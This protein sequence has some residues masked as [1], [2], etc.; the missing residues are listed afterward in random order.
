MQNI[1]RVGERRE[2]QLC[3]C[4]LTDTEFLTLLSD[5]V[6]LT[7]GRKVRGSVQTLGIT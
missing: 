6:S 4:Q 3:S 7:D 1:E 2:V 5:Q